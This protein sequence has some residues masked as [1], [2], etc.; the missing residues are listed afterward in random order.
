[1]SFDPNTDRWGDIWSIFVPDLGPGTLYHFQAEGPFIPA[2]GQRFQSQNRLIDPYARALAGTFQPSQDG[3]L[4]PPKCV[5]V[6]DYFDWEGDRHLNRKL[7]ETVIY[8]LHVKGFTQDDSS[9]VS[10]PGTYQGVIEKIPY[11]QSLGVT[12][13]ELMPVHEFPIMDFDGSKPDRK[14]YW[15]YDPMAFF[16]PHRGYA[17]DQS[18]GGQVN[19]FKQMVK[20]LHQAGIE[21]I[22][23]VVF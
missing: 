10:S 9:G 6:D 11:L 23:D 22:L 1:I 21:V 8:E 20:E 5:V 16:A 19:E 3:I 14:N 15:G 7:S 12:A 18:P 4:R 2:S 13:V 17:A